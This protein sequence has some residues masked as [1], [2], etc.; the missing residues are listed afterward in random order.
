MT[1]KKNNSHSLTN[2]ISEQWKI[3]MVS[4]I[5]FDLRTIKLEGGYE[6]YR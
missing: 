2:V 6:D 1:L 3:K 5:W 4:E